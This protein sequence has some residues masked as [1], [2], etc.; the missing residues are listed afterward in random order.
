MEANE[1][2]EV[3]MDVGLSDKYYPVIDTELALSQK[4]QRIAVSQ[5]FSPA[6]PLKCI[7]LPC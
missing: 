2:N 4:S 6:A 3:E 1:A 5:D 7:S